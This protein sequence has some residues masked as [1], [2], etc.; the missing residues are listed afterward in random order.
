MALGET[1]TD[2]GGRFYRRAAIRDG[3][4][5]LF[6]VL[7]L[8]PPSTS[9]TVLPDVGFSIRCSQPATEDD[10][11]LGLRPKPQDGS[12][13]AR[14]TALLWMMPSGRH[15]MKGHR[16]KTPQRRDAARTSR[17]LD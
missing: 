10:S 9:G 14:L 13:S 5:R 15:T 4:G 1:R 7:Q 11:N 8:P 17:N 3:A 2:L 12:L 6:P 16:R